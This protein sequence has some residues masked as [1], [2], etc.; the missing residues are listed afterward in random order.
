MTCSVPTYPEARATL[1]D[2]IHAGMEEL[3]AACAVI[4]D[5]SDDPAE[6]RQARELR[7]RLQAETPRPRRLPGWRRL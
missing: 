7:E 1:A 2:A 5:Q 4:E 6:A 3:I